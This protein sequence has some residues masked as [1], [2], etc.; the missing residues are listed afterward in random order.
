MSGLETCMQSKNPTHCFMTLGRNLPSCHVF[1][2]LIS[3]FPTPEC[4][5]ICTQMVSYFWRVHLYF[6]VKRACVH[7]TL[8]SLNVNYSGSNHCCYHGCAQRI[9]EG[10]WSPLHACPL[11]LLTC[12]LYSMR[13]SYTPYDIPDSSL[14]FLTPAPLDTFGISL[15]LCCFLRIQHKVVPAGICGE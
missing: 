9:L 1:C 5:G 11:V 6:G 10:W 8:A 3:V 4:C 13:L 7:D 14:A 12:P 15:F 2:P